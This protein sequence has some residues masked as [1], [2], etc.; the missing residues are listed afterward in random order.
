MQYQAF[1]TDYD[2]TLACGGRVQGRTIGALMRARD[3]GRILILVTGRELPNLRSVFADL[4]LFTLIVAENGTL[5]YSPA[6]GEETALCGAPP[7]PLVQRLRDRGVQPLSVGRCVVATVRA[8]EAA[9]LEAIHELRL[10]LQIIFNRGSVMV[11]P[12]GMDKGTGL[13]AALCR[14]H[15]NRESV[16]GIG[17]AENDLPLLRACG[18]PVA[19]ANAVPSLKETA[20]LVTVGKCGEGVA[21]AITTILA[22]DQP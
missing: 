10:D 20:R 4:G 18:F 9:V 2:E 6:T 16:V 3:S 11:L 22:T 12:E 17:D 15:L 8:H 21:E 19:V 1:A 13:G 5:L 7:Q 14:L